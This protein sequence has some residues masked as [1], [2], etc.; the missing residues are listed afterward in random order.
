MT[1]SLLPNLVPK[2]MVVLIALSSCICGHVQV[3][4]LRPNL[5]GFIL[6]SEFYDEECFPGTTKPAEREEGGSHVPIK[7]RSHNTTYSAVN[8]NPLYCR[9]EMSCLWELAWLQAH[10]HPSVQ[11]F[12]KKISAV[13]FCKKIYIF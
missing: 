10:F 11:A 8:R 2:H 4:K 7:P 9:A 6:Q 1:V 13:C 5:W 3:L 12:A